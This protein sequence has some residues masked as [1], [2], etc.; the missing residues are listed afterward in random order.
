VFMKFDDT[1]VV[2]AI[3]DSKVNSVAA[4]DNS[5]LYELAAAENRVRFLI[6]PGNDLD[7]HSALLWLINN[8][9]NKPYGT[10]VLL[11]FLLQKMFR[12]KENPLGASGDVCSQAAWLYLHQLYFT[13]SGSVYSLGDVFTRV[14]ETDAAPLN[15]YQV[16]LSI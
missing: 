1:H 8:F 4:L 3:H 13:A 14:P 7:R 2:E 11:G 6:P 15:L 16:C 10:S 12:L 5:S 9:G